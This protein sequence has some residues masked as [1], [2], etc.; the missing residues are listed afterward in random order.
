MTLYLFIL[1]GT[2]AER[3]FKKGY[4]G[5]GWATLMLAD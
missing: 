1:I 4:C 2:G 5:K 3:F